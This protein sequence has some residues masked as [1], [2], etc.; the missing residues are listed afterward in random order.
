MKRLKYLIIFVMSL[1]FLGCGGS[2]NNTETSGNLLNCKAWVNQTNTE[3][4]NNPSQ[5]KSVQVLI[6]NPSGVIEENITYKIALIGNPTS[7][8]TSAALHQIKEWGYTGSHGG[9]LLF[10]PKASGN[11]YAMASQKVWIDFIEKEKNKAVSSTAWTDEK[12]NNEVINKVVQFPLEKG[13]DYILHLLKANVSSL[14]I[15]IVKE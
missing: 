11:Y 9:F 3:L 7:G 6:S 4:L 8:P 13:K 14:K 2:E 1:C 5:H 12:C 15:R 10:T